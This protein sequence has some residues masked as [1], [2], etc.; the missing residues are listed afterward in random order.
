MMNADLSRLLGLK[1]TETEARIAGPLI[2]AFMKE[3][4]EEKTL[5]IAEEVLETLSFETGA[6]LARIMGNNSFR[7][8]LKASEAFSEG[9]VHDLE[10]VEHNPAKFAVNITRCDYV[11]MFEEL[12]IRDLGYLLACGRDF[13]MV[14]GFNPRMKLTRPKTIMQGDDVCDFSYEIEE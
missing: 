11:K 14:K 1:T 9:G 10:I 5:K 3:F 13:A 4:G 2:K 8:Y 7:H 6:E 12:G